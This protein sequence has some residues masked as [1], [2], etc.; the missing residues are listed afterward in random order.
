MAVL[1]NDMPPADRRLDA[2]TSLCPTCLERVPGEYVTDGESVSLH[3]RCPEHGETTRRVWDSLDHWKWAR[4]FEPDA[5]FDAE[6]AFTVDN[7]HA[8]LAVIEVTSDCNLSCSYCFASS[9]PGGTHKST[10]E[11]D[12]LLQTVIDSGGTRPIQFSGG[13]PTVRDDLPELVERARELGFDHVQVNTNGIAIA[14]RE[15]Y[16]ARLAEAGVTAIYLQFDGLRAETYEALREVDLTETKHAAV[17]ACREAGLPVVLVPTV[18]PGTNDE[19]MG[20]IV[21]YALE[22]LDVVEAVN[23][24]PVA[25]FGRYETDHGRFSLDTAACRLAEGFPEIDTRDL[26][27]VPCCSAYCQ[28]ATALL[29]TDDGPVALTKFLDEA[30]FEDLSGT[31]DEADWMELVANT[32]A[33][34]D[35]A[36]CSTGCCGGVELP[37]GADELLDRVLPVSLTGFMDADAGDAERLDNCCISV[38]TPDGELVPFCGYNMTTDDGRYA[39]RNRNEWGGRPSV[40]EAVPTGRDA[41]QSNNAA[42]SDDSVPGDDD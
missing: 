19:E 33:G 42:Q 36:C 25:H 18:V 15:G 31:V 24:Q 12:E 7:D 17:D 34:K 1:S 27:P 40:T 35:A 6:G 22:N 4:E 2:T 3:R 9:G 39:I 13:E 5:A 32:P 21:R 29:P 16:A 11:V 38:P 20:D 37:T 14:E 41:S 30:L 23:F 28:S 10:E 8:C 26:M